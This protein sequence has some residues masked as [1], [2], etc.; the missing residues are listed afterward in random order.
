[1]AL[2][3][4][5]QL[6]LIENAEP[7]RRRS[8]S[9]GSVQLPGFAAGKPMRRKRFGHALTVFQVHTCCRYQKLHRQMGRDRTAADLSLHALRK[10]IDQRQTPRYPTR[11]AIEAARQL[12]ETIAKALLQ[13]RQQPSFF[14][15][16]LV[17]RP[18]QRTV[19]DQSFGLAHRPDHGLYRVTAQLLQRRDPLIAV[20]D[21]VTFN[22][23]GDRH[24]HNRGLLPRASQRRQ[25]PPVPLRPANPQ[26]FPAP[27]QLMKLKSHRPAPQPFLQLSL[28]HTRSGL[29]RAR[30]EVCPELP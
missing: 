25:Q 10:L 28:P 26:M 21:Q 6:R 9:P 7:D 8:V 12:L 29:F 14:Q 3:F 27:I 17:F 15:R 5:K 23:I 16:R 22:L 30:G 18:A 19:Q 13:F 11:A 4:Q 20:D 1:L 24:H 2:G